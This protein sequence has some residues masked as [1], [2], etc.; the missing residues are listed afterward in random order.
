MSEELVTKLT[1]LEQE[2]A[3]IRLRTLA[4]N[5][6]VSGFESPAV[7]IIRVLKKF[8]LTFGST[9]R[10]FDR[11]LIKSIGSEIKE[12]IEQFAIKSKLIKYKD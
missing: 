3:N 7:S 8:L 9:R 12:Q 6:R 10:Y 5:D 1:S 4:L 2:Q 11:D